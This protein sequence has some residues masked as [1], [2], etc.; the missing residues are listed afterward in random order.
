MKKVLN[1]NNISKD[2]F[3]ANISFMDTIIFNIW[4]LCFQFLR[5]D[6]LAKNY[7]FESYFHFLVIWLVYLV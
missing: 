6:G 2:N 1:A 7:F 3:S 5:A 4:I